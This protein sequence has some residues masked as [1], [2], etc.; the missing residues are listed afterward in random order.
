M[1][2][3]LLLG[4]ALA[5]SSTP[6][7]A[8]SGSLI[9]VEDVIE[10]TVGVPVRWTRTGGSCRPKPGGGIILGY[11]TLSTKTITMC[12][13]AGASRELMNTLQ[14]EGW[15][16]AQ[17]NCTHRP[18]LSDEEINSLLTRADRSDMRKFYPVDQHRLEGEAR[19][20]ANRFDTDPEG[21][22]RFVERHCA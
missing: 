22:V 5:L 10:E 11:Y 18:V 8:V 13:R 19:A 4:L 2:K 3:R 17:A 9:A 1:R 14:H 12:Q 6:A 16:G 7:H 21:Y 15:H 20:V